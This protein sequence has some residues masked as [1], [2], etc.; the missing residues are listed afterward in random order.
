MQLA[1]A[2][3]VHR[4]AYHG[5]RS[6]G[7]AVL[8]AGYAVRGVF[9]VSAAVL[10]WWHIPGTTQLEHQAAADGLLN[11]HLR[12]H[13]QG[14]D[15]RKARGI[16]L[17]VVAV[18]ALV[19][20]VAIARFAPWQAQGVLAAA[21][22]TALA[23]AGRPQGRTITTKAEL[24]SQVQP[25]TQ[26]VIIRALGSMGIA[27]INKAITAG[28]FPPLPSPVREDGPGWRAEVDLPYGVT[29]TQVIER[30]EQLA[31]GLRRPLGA[32]WPEPVTSE[33]AGRLELWVG[34]ADVSKAKP[35]PWPWLRT[36]GGDIFAP[37]PFGTDPRGR[38][39][40]AALIEHNWLMGS[41]PGQGKTSAVRV[42]VA[43][44]ALDP[45]AELWLHELKGTGDL[46]PFEQVSHRFVSGIDD[47]SIGYA[48]ES[49]KKL[50]AEV[51]NRAARLKK[52]DRALC[53]DKKVT[54]EIANRRSLH[55]HPLLAACDEVQN[56]FGHPKYGKQAGEDATFIIK[57]G[58]ALGVSL[59]L[60]TQRPDKD[61]LPTPV[62]GNVSTRFCLKVAGQ[63]ENDM[64]LGTS[65]YKNGARA[66]TFR[67]KIDA[68]LGYLKGE[69]NTPQVVRTYYLNNADTERA[70]KRARAIREAAGT[71]SGVAL[72]E[73][74]SGPQRDV[75][76]DVLEAFGGAPALHWA[77][78]A[79]R[80]AERSPERWE[81]TSGDAVS[82]ELRGRGV[83]SVVVTVAGERGRGCRLE[84]V[85]AAAGQP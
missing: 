18:I 73:D 42:V 54:R 53:P 68:G 8:A 49:L 32:V 67:P 5:V 76:A 1:A 83:P 28:T 38:R 7:Y 79:E 33:H 72:G 70:A 74:E 3:H 45:T 30:R 24:P 50:R 4:A 48:A 36:G 43:A 47:E 62:S 58:R 27:E 85:Q 65:A 22:F 17:A 69:E 41:M 64:I 31:S 80:L 78:L 26:D 14:R 55:L 71:L 21:A 46:D 44:A 11:D 29:A 20:A 51:M 15:T 39:A 6:P 23:R 9:T 63:I 16:I 82:A 66:T 10:P 81:G 61:S 37:F 13:K 57:I 40:D 77:E 84:A 19:L 59:V 35:A 52:L 60:A 2:R 75:L 25:P 56:L 34:R 12:L